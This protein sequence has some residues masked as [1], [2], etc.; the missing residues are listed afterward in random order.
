MKEHF[1]QF[2]DNEN[3]FKISSLRKI[4][5]NEGKLRINQIERRSIDSS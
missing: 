1:K 2:D 3:R 4:N 5:F